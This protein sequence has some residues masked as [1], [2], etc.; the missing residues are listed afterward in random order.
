MNV[1]S[2]ICCVLGIVPIIINIENLTLQCCSDYVRLF[3]YID[4]WYCGFDESA[5]LCR[6]VS[7]HGG[8]YERRVSAY[9]GFAFLC[10]YLRMIVTTFE[11]SRCM[12]EVVFS[13][14]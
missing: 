10:L 6:M 14:C 9:I 13:R 4:K 7:Y 1:S 3:V 8:D 12:D 2:P 11:A 5:H